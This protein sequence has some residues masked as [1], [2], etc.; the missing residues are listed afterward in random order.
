MKTKLIN[1]FYFFDKK[2]NGNIEKVIF[3]VIIILI[4]MAL[5]GGLFATDIM[6]RFG[7][8]FPSYF[9]PLIILGLGLGVIY[10]IRK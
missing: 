9:I 1:F 6:D 2:G 8:G 7:D 3:G 4:L 10:L 5:T